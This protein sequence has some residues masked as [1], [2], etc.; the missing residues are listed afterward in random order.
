MKTKLTIVAA[1]GL[2]IL[3]ASGCYTQLGS[4]REDDRG[5]GAYTASQDDNDSGYAENS[6]Y[7]RGQSGYY[8]DDGWNSHARLGFSYYYP[9]SYWPSYAFTAAYADPWCYDRYYAYDPWWCGTPIVGYGYGYYPS[10]FYYAPYYYY[11][12]P[13]YYYGHTYASVPVKRGTRDFGDTRGAGGTRGVGETRYD[14]PAT[15]RG[16]YN[17][18]SGARY[19]GSRGGASQSAGSAKDNG[20]QIGGQRDAAPRSTERATSQPRYD[21]GVRGWGSRNGNARGESGR[22]T[23]T[24]TTPSNGGSQSSAPSGTSTAPSR[25]TSNTGQHQ[26]EPRQ[27]HRDAGS[28][29]GS[30]PQNTP[31]PRVQS[32]PPPPPPPSS[33]GNRSGGGSRGG[34]R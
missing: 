28:S 24:Q 16:G 3:V 29:R 4:T 11:Y 32:A 14:A 5:S 7:D 1:L 34:R 25:G 8:N 12:P 17:L 23:Q 13:A 30:V 19:D 9:S 18:P 31:P 20:R 10:H 26:R 2:L 33:G 15:D 27:G 21:R 22:D 6:D